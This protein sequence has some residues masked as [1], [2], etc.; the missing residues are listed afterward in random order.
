MSASS[1]TPR[2]IGVALLLALVAGGVAYLFYFNGHL[3]KLVLAQNLEVELPLAVDVLGAMAL[4]A[5]LTAAA[6][7]LRS[8][9]ATVE[10]W[11]RRRRERRREALARVRDEGRRRLWAGDFEKAERTLRKVVEREPEDLEALLALARSYERRGELE[12]ALDVLQRGR[13]RLGSD[14]LLLSELGRLSL[15][16]GN[17]GAA[18]DAYRE[19]ERLAPGSP[20]VLSELA[21]AL[22]AEGRFAE[23]ADAARKRLLVERE[24]HRRAEARE[25]A[26]ALAYRAAVALKADPEREEALRRLVG[27]AAGFAPARVLLAELALAR[28]DRRAADKIL[29]EGWKRT[30]LGVFLERLAALATGAE[31]GARSR[32]LAALREAAKS[33]GRVAPRL[34]WARTL[35]A[36]GELE[37]A[38]AELAGIGS[39]DDAP[40]APERDLVAGELAC[41]RERHAEAA[42]LL[43]RAAT[44]AHQP[45]SHACSLCGRVRPR[46]ED[47]CRCGAFG[48]FDWLVAAEEVPVEPHQAA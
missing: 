3:V 22:A 29:R 25:E 43:D 8:L 9:G 6:G 23:A 45:F 5:L 30:R 48:R 21:R 24:A 11:R 28:G 46:W 15:A 18:I 27:D 16:A 2:R 14:P 38:A 37:G 34:L 41:A 20:F 17:A 39:D 47:Q 40:F 42:A 33:S 1:R 35:V 13:A 4:G 26:T 12:P 10:A 44:G 7:A 36:V 31:G 32:P 19:A